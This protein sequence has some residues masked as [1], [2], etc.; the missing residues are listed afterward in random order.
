MNTTALGNQNREQYVVTMKN[1][2]T[3]Q[4]T[5]AFQWIY[6]IIP[7]YTANGKLLFRNK[8]KSFRFRMWRVKKKVKTGP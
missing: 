7:N 3:T 5:N 4:F 1:V 2:T 6:N 8:N